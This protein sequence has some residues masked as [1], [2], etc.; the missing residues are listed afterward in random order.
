MV[1]AMISILSAFDCSLIGHVRDSLCV[2]KKGCKVTTLT[3]LQQ[4]E[5]SFEDN[6]NKYCQVKTCHTKASDVITAVKVKALVRQRSTRPFIRLQ[7]GHT[8]PTRVG[9]MMHS[10]ASSVRVQSL[11]CNPQGPHTPHFP[12]HPQNNSTNFFKIGQTWLILGLVD[13]VCMIRCHVRF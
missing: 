3:T 7:L 5:R 6:H 4:F 10:A 8:V 9:L 2:G 11:Q 1:H 12:L 13:N